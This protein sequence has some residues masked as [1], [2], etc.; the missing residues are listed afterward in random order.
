MILLVCRTGVRPLFS[1]DVVV[2]FDA[3]AGHSR[4]FDASGGA[5]ASGTQ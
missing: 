2:V 1:F 4:G 3:I 5:S